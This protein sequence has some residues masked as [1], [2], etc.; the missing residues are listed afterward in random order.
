MEVNKRR[1]LAGIRGCRIFQPI[2]SSSDINVTQPLHP[3]VDVSGPEIEQP[4][5]PSGAGLDVSR[6]QIPAECNPAIPGLTSVTVGRPDAGG[7]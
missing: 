6:P 2:Q 1:R 5:L 4:F 3:F 7:V